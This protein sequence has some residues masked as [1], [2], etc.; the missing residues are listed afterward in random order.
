[1]AGNPADVVN[2]R[3]QADGRLPLDQRRN[4]KH[5]IGI[6]FLF[7]LFYFYFQKKKSLHNFT[8]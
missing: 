8:I 1:M 5:A 7:F 6:I 4:Y 2:I 3:M